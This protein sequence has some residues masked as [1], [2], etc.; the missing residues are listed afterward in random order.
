MLVF[1][2][3]ASPV[4]VPKGELANRQQIYKTFGEDTPRPAVHINTP[5]AARRNGRAEDLASS[6]S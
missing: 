3:N 1:T 5:H 4:R 2:K 6:G